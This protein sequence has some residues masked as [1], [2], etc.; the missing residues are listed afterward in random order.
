[1]SDTPN[2]TDRTAY[3]YAGLTD[4]TFGYDHW[5]AAQYSSPWRDR[6]AILVIIQPGENRDEIHR[7]L[8]VALG[9]EARHE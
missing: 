7:R 6:E 3:V 5:R 4:E 8:L 2:L 1:M 9:S